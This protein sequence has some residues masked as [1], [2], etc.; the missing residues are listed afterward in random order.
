[1]F[2]TTTKGN[3]IAR[4]T[5]AR[6]T[7]S[8]M[9][10][11]G[12]NT[13]FFKPYSTRS[14]AVSKKA[15]QTTSSLESVLQMG[16]WRGTS[17]FFKFYLRRV[18][19]F[20]R[21]HPKNAE[22]PAVKLQLSSDSNAQNQY[23]LVPA[24][25]ARR[26]ANHS[27]CRALLQKGNNPKNQCSRIYH[28]RQNYNSPN[29]SVSS[30]FT[31]ETDILDTSFTTTVSTAMSPKHKDNASPGL[32]GYDCE[33]AG[34]ENNPLLLDHQQNTNVY[35][36]ISTPTPLQPIAASTPEKNVQHLDRVSVDVS[37]NKLTPFSHVIQNVN[38]LPIVCPVNVIRQNV[39]E[40]NRS[41]ADLSKVP[42]AFI[43]HGHNNVPQTF[44]RILFNVVHTSVPPTT[45]HQVPQPAVRSL[46]N[47]STQITFRLPPPSPVT[48][49]SKTVFQVPKSKPP[50]APKRKRNKQEGLKV[51]EK[52]IN[53]RAP[54]PPKSEEDEKV[55][56][57]MK[58]CLS[59]I[60][61]Q[62]VGA[63][64]LLK[65]PSLYKYTQKWQSTVESFK[66]RRIIVNP[67]PTFVFIGKSSK[68]EHQGTPDCENQ[69][70]I[71]DKFITLYEFREQTDFR[72]TVSNRL[73]LKMLIP[74]TPPFALKKMLCDL[75]YPR[76]EFAVTNSFATFKFG[77]LFIPQELRSVFLNH[78]CILVDYGPKVTGV[79]LTTS[80]ILRYTSPHAIFKQ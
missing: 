2:I 65:L 23:S 42:H 61:E 78:G 13:S 48:T 76:K 41:V 8:A 70:E 9:E 36:P 71:H 63:E 67:K 80:D 5:L 57:E 15:S 75:D 7:K 72:I 18:K 46:P 77:A 44:I 11:S 24:S 20:S 60:T 50:C 53:T 27:L 6:W 45:Q 74:N 28:H 62:V 1:M 32:D 31:E 79:C 49:Q 54:P 35:G 66:T 58:I 55:L 39:G 68:V 4:A 73:S 29:P 14:A 25:P 26:I 40:F 19:Y 21:T 16:N 59:N 34:L 17:S 51:P 64:V 43:Q 52:N 56:K 38:T 30:H 10:K 33:I 22:K 47:Q 12:I 69:I 37:Q 3:S